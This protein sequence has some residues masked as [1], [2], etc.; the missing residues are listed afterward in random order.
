VNVA[1]VIRRLEETGSS[2]FLLYHGG[3]MAAPS[4]PK[5]GR[6]EFGPGLYLTTSYDLARKY[7]GGSRRVYRCEVARGNEINSVRIPAP[8]VE[9]WL[10]LYGGTKRKQILADLARHLKDGTYPVSVLVNLCINCDLRSSSAA[11]LRAFLVEHGVSY[12]VDRWS[13]GSVADTYILTLFDDSLLLNFKPVP[14]PGDGER[15]F[16]KPV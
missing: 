1:A 9:G 12:S 4:A 14:D 7:G 13:G 6:W 5:K 10:K 3:T 8:A 16:P 15:N 2:S 11:A